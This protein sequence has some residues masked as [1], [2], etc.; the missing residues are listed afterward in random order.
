M[1]AA[2]QELV[3]YMAI[4]RGVWRRHKALVVC[5]F[6][7]IA[8][9]LL[10]I[11]QFTDRPL[12]VSTA[13][14]S[15]EPSVLDQ[16]P[17]L[18]DPV[19]RDTRSA[20]MVLLKSR[21]LS[22]A[23][24]EA[25]PREGFDELLRESQYT[26]YL[27]L[28]KNTIKPWLGQPPTVL[29][30][31]ELAMAEL[32]MA[33]M[34]FLPSKEAPNI[35]VISATATR[36]RIAM[37]LVNAYIQVLLNRTRS[38]DQDEARRAR[39]FLEQQFQQAKEN[40]ARAEETIAG[41][42]QRKG[43]VALRGQTELDLVRL[44]QLENSLAETQANRQ[45]LSARIA[46]LRG[47]AEQLK[48]KGART[49]K[50]VQ[51]DSL[52]DEK[53]A[54]VTAF[55]R[56]QDQLAKLEAKLST[57]RERYTEAHPLVQVTQDEVI[58]Q[59]ALVAQMAR[60]LPTMP[61]TKGPAGSSMISSSAED[62]SD[63]VAQL[64]SL[65]KE[66]GNLEA[67]EASLNLQLTR[68]R[69]GLHNLNQDEMQFGNMHR[70]LEVN[71]SLLS[72]LSDKLMATRIREQGEP[73][74]IRIVDPASL[75]SLPTGSK[76]Q[77]LVLMVLGLAGSLAFGSAF[78]LE[79]WRQP[80]E[81]ETDV[82]KATGLPVLGSVAAMKRPRAGGRGQRESQSS[83]PLFDPNLSDRSANANIQIDLYRAIR[84]NVETERLKSPFRSILVTSPGPHEGKS[85]TTLNLAH[86]FQEFG[87]RVLLVEA[88]LRRP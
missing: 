41:F 78:G 18:R 11:V 53:L 44:S 84:A 74:V 9:P 6:L 1:Q 14:I 64:A 37:E 57:L 60:Q 7:G 22:H 54:S 19:K 34:E 16:I 83:R 23:V 31:E 28:L 45:I 80:I 13:T 66:S 10:V 58:K 2:K 4:L 62:L 73:G 69:G 38:V 32:Q 87:R 79:F 88:D 39:E 47:P 46:A 52:A 70:S 81:T 21:S 8:V 75:P 59:Q 5:T 67:K 3:D 68:L 24:I 56:A 85:T 65:E 36:P 72:A 63:A 30:P 12:Y 29:S 51:A 27:L 82:T 26:D 43:R 61:S 15:I 17:F 40:V 71:R 55:K 48:S 42:Q 35:I 76:T 77:K 33:R 20:H 50:E 25:L 86:V 49:S